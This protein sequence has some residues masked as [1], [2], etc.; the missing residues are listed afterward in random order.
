[1]RFA[2]F[3]TIIAFGSGV[4]LAHV[5]EAGTSLRDCPDCPEMTVIPPGSFMMG[6]TPEEIRRAGLPEERV[7]D[8]RPRRKVTI[9]KP[10]AVSKFEITKAEFAAFAKA[11]NFTATPDCRVTHNDGSGGAKEQG[12]TWQDPK[13]DGPGIAPHGENHPVICV[14]WDDA[15]AYAA[16]LA[17]T[18]DQ[19]YRLLTEAEWEYAARAGSTGL[20][21]WGD[22]FNQA[23]EFANAPDT[24]AKQIIPSLVTLDCDDGHVRT[25]PV[26]SFQP[27][28]FGLYDMIGNVWEWVADCHTANY[29]GAPSDG[30]VGPETPGCKRVMRGGAWSETQLNFRSAKRGQGAV[31]ER[32][33]SIG[34]RV[35]RTFN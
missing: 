18:T 31:D 13:V 25:A 7:Q 6:S 3:L 11:T 4:A 12:R 26:G 1:M 33:D 27:N 2:L 34:I 35:V 5:P 17:K 20:N 14:G 19:H 29:A 8:E 30:G 28:A 24:R 9:A 15:T 21:S 22:N 10:L 16:W 23:C 32:S